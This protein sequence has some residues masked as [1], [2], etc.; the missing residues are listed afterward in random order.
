MRGPWTGA[1]QT[2]VWTVFPAHAMSRGRPTLTESKRAV[3]FSS[4]HDRGRL[5]SALTLMSALG[6]KRTCAPQNGMSALTPKADM[7]SAL[8]HVRFV[9]IAD[10]IGQAAHLGLGISICIGMS[11]GVSML[12]PVEKVGRSCGAARTIKP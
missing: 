4:H 7:C 1:F 9:P 2:A 6:H 10:I 11:A 8:V 3:T 5:R 12:W